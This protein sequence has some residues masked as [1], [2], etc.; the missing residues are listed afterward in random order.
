M[1]SLQQ[2]SNFPDLLLNYYHRFPQCMWRFIIYIVRG[3][4]GQLITQCLHHL[5]LWVKQ[6]VIFSVI[7]LFVCIL[8]ELTCNK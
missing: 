1:D 3:I 4:N 6:A 8:V 2:T 7:L 5:N